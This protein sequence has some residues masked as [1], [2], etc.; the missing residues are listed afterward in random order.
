MDSEAGRVPSCPT[1]DLNRQNTLLHHVPSMG[2]IGGYKIDDDLLVSAIELRGRGYKPLA[3]F[4]DRRV[5]LTNFP[6]Y[7]R[8]PF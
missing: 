5:I 8:T 6:S 3:K 2:P 4:P 7:F 1:Y